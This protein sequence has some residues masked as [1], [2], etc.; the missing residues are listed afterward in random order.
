MLKIIKPLIRKRA[1]L[2]LLCLIA[3]PSIPVSGT[4]QPKDSS[5]VAPLPTPIATA[6]K[7]F[8]SNAPGDSL[9]TSLGGPARPYQEF[10]AAMKSWGHYQLLSSP[11]DADL[12]LEISFSHPIVGVN[13]MS[14]SGG[15]STSAL[16]LKLVIVDAKTLAVAGEVP[17]SAATD[18]IGY[19]PETGLVHI[20]NDTAAEQWVI[21]PVA[22]KIVTS[23]KF[24]GTG[25]E[26]MALDLKNRRLYQAVKGANS[27][28]EVD[29]DDN[30]VL[31]AW[32]LAP[33]KGPHG[34]ACVPD[35]N[36]LLVA[37]AG[38]L[39][40]LSCSNGKILATA[41]IG[42]R[43]DEMTYDHGLHMAYCASRMGKI[44]AVS[45]GPNTLTS[46]GDVPDVARTGD[47]TMDPATH[48]VWIAYPQD[49][50]CFAQPFTPSHN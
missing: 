45:V 39:V 40:M 46:A 33:D 26:D 27:I 38:N 36:N 2:C 11:A 37:C 23:I 5:P 3:L 9:P 49:G 28:V 47:I 15:G 25:L 35:Y 7:V 17:L 20:C 44:S 34:I 6:Q 30:K 18:L 48:T 19:D 42:A 24:D 4:Q 29:L 8:I 50:K 14:T 32:P 12:I 1:T 13:V 21:D 16:L 22:K 10:Y 31:A 43:V 41:P